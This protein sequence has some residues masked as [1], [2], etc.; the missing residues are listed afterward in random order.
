MCIYRDS[1][2]DF[3]GMSNNLYHQAWPIRWTCQ[4]FQRIFFSFCEVKPWT[5]QAMF[6]NTQTVAELRYNAPTFHVEE[7]PYYTVLPQIFKL[8]IIVVTPR[9]MG[10]CSNFPRS[11]KIRWDS[12]KILF[13]SPPADIHS[14]WL[15]NPVMFDCTCF[16][17]IYCVVI[18]RNMWCVGG[19]STGC[20]FGLTSKYEIERNEDKICLGLSQTRTAL[21][22]LCFYS[23][24]TKTLF[25]PSRW[26]RKLR[27]DIN[28]FLLIRGGKLS[29][30]VTE[31]RINVF[32]C[33]SQSYF[34]QF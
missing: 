25:R 10:N 17:C 3:L 26:T 11:E 5:V 6:W 18:C 4:I 8:L 13:L 16:E 19:V 15:N 24:S 12:R 20:G 9:I 32:L 21:V 30:F 23:F 7:I 1:S 29:F 31:K 22:R 28:F 34:S 33:A 2:A 14:M 27:F